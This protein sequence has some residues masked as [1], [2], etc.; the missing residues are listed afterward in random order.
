MQQEGHPACKKVSGGVSAWLSVLSEVQTCIWPSWCHCHSLSLASVK[1]GW[2]LPFWYRLIQVVLDGCV[3]VC[4]SW[5]LIDS[6]SSRSGF[7]S[8]CK[9]T[10]VWSRYRSQS[11]RRHASDWIEISKSSIESDWSK[12]WGWSRE[13]SVTFVWSWNFVFVDLISCSYKH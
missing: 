13:N 3:C 4:Y 7:G 10:G 6:I 2:V 11:R 8:C 1:S 5:C 9:Q 12:K